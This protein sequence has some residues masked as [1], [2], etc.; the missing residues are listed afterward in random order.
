M[1]GDA[2]EPTPWELMRGIERLESAVKDLGGKVV[3]TDVYLAD[4]KGA[5]ERATR[6]ESR[7]R[8]LEGALQ[9]AEKLRRSQRFTISLAIASPVIA[10]VMAFVI[11][12]GLVVR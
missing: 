5:D 12:G 11:A 10:C 1:A 3:S 7:I 6:A 8:D 9:E 4:K 2:A